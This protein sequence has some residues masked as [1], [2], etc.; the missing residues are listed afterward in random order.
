M[1][2]AMTMIINKP[3]VGLCLNLKLTLSTVSA[4]LLLCDSSIVCVVAVGLLSPLLIDATLNSFRIFS[5]IVVVNWPSPLI[6]GDFGDALSFVAAGLLLLLLL[7]AKIQAL[8]AEQWV[9]PVCRW[10]ALVVNICTC[11]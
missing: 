11:Y 3:E 7:L 10:S 6:S 4:C 1:L 5:S 8:L 2:D 9:A